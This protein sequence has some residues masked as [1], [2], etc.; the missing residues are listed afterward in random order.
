[1]LLFSVGDVLLITAVVV[2]VVD[3]SVTVYIAV[4]NIHVVRYL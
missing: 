2:V 1:M 3:V 4:M